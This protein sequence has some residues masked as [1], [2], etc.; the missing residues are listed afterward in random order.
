MTARMIRMRILGLLLL[1]LLLALIELPDSVRA[2]RPAFPLLALAVV[3]FA[4]RSGW[5]LPVA[6]VYGICLDTLFGA[7][8]GQHALVLTL[9]CFGVIKL[10]SLMRLLALWQSGLLMLPIWGLAGFLL[11]WMD[12]TAQHAASTTLRWLPI[13]STAV[14]WPLVEAI[15]RRRQRAAS[16]ARH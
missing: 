13:L 11:F 12:G 2:L 8:L 15:A 16:A 4:T 1:G 10:S 9:L 6:W 3:A 5:M 7:P 14:C